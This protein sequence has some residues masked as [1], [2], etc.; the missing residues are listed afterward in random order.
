[1]SAPS[2][3]YAHVAARMELP[4]DILPLGDG[5]Y[6]LNFGFEASLHVSAADWYVIDGAMR[7]AIA[8][9]MQAVAV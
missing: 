5:R 3:P 1:M 4:P 7:A 6:A 2:R 9:D 8:A